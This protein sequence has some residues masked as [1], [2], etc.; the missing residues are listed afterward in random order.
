MSDCPVCRH[1]SELRA[2]MDQVTQAR[3]HLLSAIETLNKHSR[4]EDAAAVEEAIEGGQACG[5]ALQEDVASAQQTLQRW[6]LTTSNEAKLAKAL[7]AGTS[8]TW[9]SRAIQ[10]RFACCIPVVP[11]QLQAVYPD[12]SKTGVAGFSSDCVLYPS[13]IQA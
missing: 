2:R 10:V 5:D 7:S 9:L 4:P 11:L 6:Q 3:A 1:A 12:W 13:R 8:V